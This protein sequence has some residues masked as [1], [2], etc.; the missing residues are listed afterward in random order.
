MSYKQTGR[1]HNMKSRF[2]ITYLA[3]SYEVSEQTLVS[4]TGVPFTNIHNA[5]FC[6]YYSYQQKRVNCL[7]IFFGL[8]FS[9]YGHAYGSSASEV[10]PKSMGKTWD[11]PNTQQNILRVFYT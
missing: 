4:L 9:I 11:G 1:V 5:V 2:A 10:M 7:Y 6:L 3:Y 8:P